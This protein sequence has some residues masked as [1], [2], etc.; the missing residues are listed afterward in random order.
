MNYPYK[1]LIFT[2]FSV[3][4]VN[5]DKSDGYYILSLDYCHNSI[6]SIIFSTHAQ[7]S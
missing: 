5:A 2:D 4:N 7:T 1:R 6:V 3:N